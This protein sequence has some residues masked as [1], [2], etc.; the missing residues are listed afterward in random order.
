MQIANDVF[1][2]S[3]NKG[4]EQFAQKVL[5][6]LEHEQKCIMDFFELD[7]MSKKVRII[8]YNDL[9]KFIDLQTQNGKYP[10]RYQGWNVATVKNGDI[11]ILNFDLYRKAPQHEGTTFEDYNKT[12][13]HEFVHAC[14]EEILMDKNIMPP[15]LMEGI[16]TQLAGQTKY[17]LKSTIDCEARDLIENFYATRFSYAFAYEIMGYLLDTKT[18]EEVLDILRAPQNVDVQELIDNTNEYL[19]QS[20][21]LSPRK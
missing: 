2:I 6:V 16:A 13:T 7:K 14:H 17:K 9:Q 1:E 4:D 18:H 5:G 8:F 20:R 10:N 3:F 12:L 19:T 15:L 21:S 11:H